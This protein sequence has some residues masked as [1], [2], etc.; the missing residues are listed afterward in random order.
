ME[1]YTDE[2]VER[3]Y[4]EFY[5]DVHTEFLK[6]GQIENFKVCRNSSFHLRGNVY[7]HYK[8]LESAVLAYQ[9]FN[10]RYF[11]GKQVTCEFVNITRWKVAICGEYM[12]SR[13]QNC[14]RGS[15]CN[16]IHCFRNPGGDYEWADWDKPPPMF[17]MEKMHALFGYSEATDRYVHNEEKAGRTSGNA[18]TDRAGDSRRSM[19]REFEQQNDGYVRKRD[20]EDYSEEGGGWKGRNVDS[21]KRGSKNIQE[22]GDGR[23]LDYKWSGG[24]SDREVESNRKREY[25]ARRRSSWKEGYYDENRKKDEERRER[26]EVDGEGNGGGRDKEREI[27]QRKS[28]TDICSR[29]RSYGEEELEDDNRGGMDSPL[30][31][32]SRERGGG[33]GRRRWKD[34]QE[35][36]D[37]DDD[38]TNKLK[39]KKKKKKKQLERESRSKGNI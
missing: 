36:G 8:S 16:F 20:R 35:S 27:R 22:E 33:K 24:W 15:A 4:E 31:K 26:S 7:V 1:Y 23:R 34:D 21:G 6:Y 37:D 11:A 32:E 30:E 2:E 12:K 18:N 25:R 14:S 19:S 3:S 39:L 10:G 38:G 29:R 17:W 5:E 9:F 13:L 28:K